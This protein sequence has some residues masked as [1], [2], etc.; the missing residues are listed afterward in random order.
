LN[1]DAADDRCRKAEDNSV[2]L[3]VRSFY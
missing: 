2:R 1:G 3:H